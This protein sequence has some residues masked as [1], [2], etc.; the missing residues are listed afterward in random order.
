[1]RAAADS[2][3]PA[4]ALSNAPS[5]R[6]GMPPSRAAANKRSERSSVKTD[7]SAPIA[8][9]CRIRCEKFTT[10]GLG[11]RNSG[12]LGLPFATAVPLFLLHIDRCLQ[13]DAGPLS[14]LA[15]VRGAPCPDVGSSLVHHAMRY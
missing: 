5:S 7:S 2:S 14:L 6:S 9:S 4:S 11:W 12:E 13:D 1:M 8:A 15:R 3:R 10:R